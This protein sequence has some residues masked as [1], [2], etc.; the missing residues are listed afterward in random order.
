[1]ADRDDTYVRGIVV[2]SARV[3]LDVLTN[4]SSLTGKRQL[5]RKLRKLLSDVTR[6]TNLRS[7]R[8]AIGPSMQRVTEGVDDSY[9]T[10]RMALGCAWW[11]SALL[12]KQ[13]QKTSVFRLTATE[14]EHAPIHID[15]ERVD[16]EALLDTRR[17]KV[18]AFIG[19]WTT[20][21]C[22]LIADDVMS[23]RDPSVV[24]VV[25]RRKMWRS[26]VED[27]VTNCGVSAILENAGETEYYQ[28]QFQKV[29]DWVERHG[30]EGAFREYF[31]GMRDSFGEPSSCDGQA[32]RSILTRGLRFASRWN[33]APES[34]SSCAVCSA[35]FSDRD[36]MKGLFR[37]SRCSS[38]RYCSREC[39]KEDW[40]RHK[41]H[42]VPRG[43]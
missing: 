43:S 1:M 36:R 8:E 31:D 41:E 40:P 34:V 21:E 37:C 9:G 30:V 25:V 7:V 3:A 19:G 13:L 18:A 5:T 23:D 22:E 32:T 29:M 42:C 12:Q 2:D 16:D 35:V 11:Q 33:D 28:R 6:P 24:A 17:M 20:A 26:V 15:N 4:A 14:L 39:Q 27:C 10:L 38:V